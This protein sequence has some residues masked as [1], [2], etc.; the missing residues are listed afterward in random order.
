MRSKELAGAT[1]ETEP[2]VVILQRG[3]HRAA[4]DAMA[5]GHAQYP[6]F[7]YVFRDERR[8]A[9]ALRAFFAATVRDAIPFGSVLA[10]S[11]GSRVQAAAVWLPPG[12]FPWSVARKLAATPTLGRV[13]VADTGAFPTFVRY[14]ENVERAHP[15]QPHWYL[16]A[17]SVRPECQG[18]RL[19]SRLVKPILERADA[20][21]VPCY[22]E[23]SDPANIAFYR[24]FGFEVVD[25]ALVVIPGGPPLTRMWR[26]VPGSAR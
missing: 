17:L 15:H 6:S 7:R 19:G 26:A 13:A 10:V 8:R 1:P 25:P 14:G 9:R 24:R 16:E 2:A 23:T 20:E 22:L 4:A 21:G 3:Q 12:A 5:A 11:D 18:R